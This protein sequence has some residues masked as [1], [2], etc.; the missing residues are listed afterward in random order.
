MRAGVSLVT[1]SN[2]TQFTHTGEGYLTTRAG[3]ALPGGVQGDDGAWEA[4]LTLTGYGDCGRIW[5]VRGLGV[6]SFIDNASHNL[7]ALCGLRATLRTPEL[8]DRIPARRVALW[9]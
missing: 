5:I 2:S 3:E 4:V 6:L 7:I 8:S 9:L 1:R